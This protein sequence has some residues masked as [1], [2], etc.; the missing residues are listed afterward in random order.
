M[1]R[2]GNKQVSGERRRE[3]SGNLGWEVRWDPLME[4]LEVTE[5]LCILY[6]SKKREKGVES[7]GER[8]VEGEESGEEDRRQHDRMLAACAGRPA[9]TDAPLPAWPAA[10]LAGVPAVHHGGPGAGASAD[11]IPDGSHEL[12]Q[13]LGGLGDPVVWPHRV[14]KV[15]D[16]PVCIE[17]F[18]L[19]GREDDE[20][21]DPRQTFESD[22][23]GHAATPMSPNDGGGSGTKGI[24]GCP[25][26]LRWGLL[27]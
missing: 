26:S 4:G 9:R 13:G 5:G 2:G 23:R 1:A 12:D 20:R 10:S 25:V 24:R 18:L 14:V 6:S 19:E 16:E 21:K 11:V 22:N 15:A 7:E 3:V 17:L 8:Q 27:G